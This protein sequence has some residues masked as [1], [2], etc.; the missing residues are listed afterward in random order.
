MS[1]SFQVSIGVPA[2]AVVLPVERP[3]E[4]WS[5]WAEEAARLRLGPD[6]DGS[7]VA[8]FSE[9]LR[10]ALAD[11]ATRE[12]VTALSFCPEPGAGEL[13]RIEVST[14][15]PAAPGDP[16]LTVEELGRFLSTPTGRSMQPAEIL[17]G[18]LPIGPAVRVRHQYVVDRPAGGTGDADEAAG[19]EDGEG[20]LLQTVAYAA[21]P[22]QTEGAVLLFVSWQA[23]A[24]TDRL[25]DLVDHLATTLRLTSEP[26]G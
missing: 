22:P 14:I 25:G 16:E 8:L 7:D 17:Y 24:F 23:L 18:D 6:A 3:E 4:E 20:N 12:P 13:A 10:G 26:Q 2:G 9:A 15:A 19:G 11:A 21:R 1:D 5:A